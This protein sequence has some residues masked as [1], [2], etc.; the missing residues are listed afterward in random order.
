MGTMTGYLPVRVSARELPVYK[1]YVASGVDPHQGCRD[2]L[3]SVLVY[4]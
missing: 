4:L 3:R 2:L 1:D